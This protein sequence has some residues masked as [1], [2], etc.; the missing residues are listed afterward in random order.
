MKRAIALVSI[1]LFVFQVGCKKA[2][3]DNAGRLVDGKSDPSFDARHSSSGSVERVALDPQGKIIIGG[4]FDHS[5]EGVMRRG[6]SR[7][8]PDGTPDNSFD[9]EYGIDLSGKVGV[10]ALQADGKII[11][12]GSFSYYN[13]E[14]AENIARINPD[15]S[16]D[17]S[18]SCRSITGINH[19][20][21]QPDG[22]VLVWGKMKNKLDAIVDNIARLNTDGSFD[23][24]FDAGT[25]I[26]LFGNAKSG[27][28]VLQPDGK[29]IVTGWFTGVNGVERNSVARLN[30]DGSLDH[31]FNVVDLK[32]IAWINTCYLLDDGKILIGGDGILAKLNADGSLDHSF[33]PAATQNGLSDGYANVRTLAVQK[34]GKILIGGSYALNSQID[35]RLIRLNEDGSLDN[36][37]E[38]DYGANRTPKDILLQPDGKIIINSGM[39]TENIGRLLNSD[40]F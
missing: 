39:H 23:A 20:T 7:L 12:G 16:L 3:D 28:I 10:L 26:S 4:Q 32:P 29:I 17:T 15:G 18:F 6:L 31:S 30:P 37:F 27:R 8:N 14:L 19:L 11:I 21:L 35:S 36:T 9:T 13:R 25:G 38:P 1:F 34:N 2:K 24:S 33:K 40:G 22:K 5:S